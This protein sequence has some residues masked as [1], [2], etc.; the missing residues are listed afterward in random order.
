MRLSERRQGGILVPADRSRRT[1]TILIPLP[2]SLLRAVRKPLRWAGAILAAVAIAVWVTWGRGAAE[3]LCGVPG[4]AQADRYGRVHE[5]DLPWYV[6]PPQ[7]LLEARDAAGADRLLA[8]F[9]VSFPDPL[10]EETANVAA[11]AGYL[12]GTVLRPGEPVSVNGILGPYTEARGYRPG[13]SYIGGRL[14]PSSGGGV[15]KVSTALYNAA[16]LAGVTVLERHPHSMP[17]PYVPPGRDAAVAWGVKDLRLRVDGDAPVVAWAAVQGH[18]LY[19]ALYG[20]YEPPRVEWH[21]E[22]LARAPHSTVRRANPALPPGEERVVVPGADGVTVRTAVTITYPGGP[23]VRRELGVD[24]YRPLPRLV[25]FGPA[26]EGS[27][28]G[29]SG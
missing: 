24:T 20:S 3:A 18:T 8:A 4:T 23:P 19:V 11:A 10:F 26:P 5:Q 29:G 12:A 1:R 17:V 25:E 15:C 21:Q 27:S 6:N 14:V 9:R 13:P 22:E 28:P 16:M 7:R 2:A